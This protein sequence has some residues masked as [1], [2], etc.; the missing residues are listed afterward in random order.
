MQREKVPKSWSSRSLRS[1]STTSV[2]FS[3][4]GSRIELPGVE[5]H[6]EALA[7]AL[8][9]PDDAD[10]LVALCGAAARPCVDRVVDRVELVVAGDLL[11]TAAALVLEDDEVA[12]RSRNRRLLEDAPDQDLELGRA[13]GGAAPRPSIVRQGM[14]RSR[15]AVERADPRLDAV[16]DDQ[17]LVEREERRDLVLVRLELVEGGPDR[18]VL[19]GRV[20]ELDHAERQAVDEERRCPAGARAGPRRR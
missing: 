3:I 15:P 20:L 18:R 19:V 14:N 7:R 11:A 6:R 8:G 17:H 5:G 1:V 13:P 12:E 2:G 10:P 9:V 4:A 16:G